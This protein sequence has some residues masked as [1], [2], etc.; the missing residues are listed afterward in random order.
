MKKMPIG[1]V[2]ASSIKWG[3]LKEQ[4]ENITHIKTILLRTIKKNYKDN[5]K[6]PQTKAEK[7]K[8]KQSK[9]S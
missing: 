7:G 6:E 1:W 5:Y 4:N 8:E 2:F 9:E 3:T